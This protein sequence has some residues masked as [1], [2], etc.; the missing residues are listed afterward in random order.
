MVL[1]RKR[2]WK[3]A[4]GA[5]LFLFTLAIGNQFI[6]ADRNVHRTMLGHDFLV[7]Y[8]GG[9][10]ARTGQYDQLYHMETLRRLEREAGVRFGLEMGPGY[11][12]WWNPPHAAWIFAPFSCF[13]YPTALLLWQL[14]S[15]AMFAAS[16]AMLARMLPPGSTW[17]TWALIPLLT[18]PF[19]P[20][21]QAVS[22]GQNTFLTL[23]LLTATV[24]LWRTNRAYTAGLV[25]GL[26][27]YKPQHAAVVGIVL[28]ASLGW[29]A[30][31][32]LATT[33]AVTLL[34]TLL[35]TPGQLHEFLFTM[36]AN[37]K[38]FQ[39]AN[40]YLWERHMTFKGF[41]RLLIQGHELGETTSAV[42]V[43][44]V[45]SWLA[46][47]AT[48]ARAIWQSARFRP[49]G[50]GCLQPVS[51]R[52]TAP[53]ACK[54]AVPHAASRAIGSHDRLIAATVVATP[55]L[56]PFYFDYDLVLLIIAGTL[57]TGDRLRHGPRE[58]DIRVELAWIALFACTTFANLFAGM[59]RISFSVIP[60]TALAFLL[61]Q[62]MTRPVAQP[63]TSEI[64]APLPNPLIQLAA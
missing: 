10:L 23:F 16:V 49:C 18:I 21:L 53:T 37:L 24:A 42:L 33:G 51:S 8:S 60:L 58:G 43:L 25:C 28:T 4:V 41:W 11:G 32:G 29:R 54:Q 5:L 56:V 13:D 35:A 63:A 34:V 19:V 2:L 38:T 12:P 22:H 27:A 50:T 14:V 47:A 46:L 64:A 61:I 55:L 9:L 26:L 59:T 1:S 17:K 62:R 15:A 36:P 52:I 20:F 45:S 7:F 3:F 48:F 6:S 31:A 44:W 40:R 57:Y 39:E 30:A